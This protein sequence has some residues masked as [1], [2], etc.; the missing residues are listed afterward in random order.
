MSKIGGR[1]CAATGKMTLGGRIEMK[2]KAGFHGIGGRN[3]VAHRSVG[4]MVVGRNTSWK[5]MSGSAIITV[6]RSGFCCWRRESA[7]SILITLTPRQC[8]CRVLDSFRMKKYS[9]I[10]T[11]VSGY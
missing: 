9:Y 2:S 5:R 3:Y 1:F 8:S 7:I 11:K 4:S 6:R 10:G